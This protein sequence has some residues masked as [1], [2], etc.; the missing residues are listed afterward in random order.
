MSDKSRLESAEKLL[1]AHHRMFREIQK[2]LE[3]A[4]KEFTRLYDEIE[5]LGHRLDATEDEIDARLPRNE[6][7]QYVTDPNPK[8]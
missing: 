3:E 5:N 1:V 2:A 7:K 8:G 4:D 6:G